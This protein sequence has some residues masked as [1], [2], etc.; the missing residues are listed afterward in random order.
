M[1]FVYLFSLILLVKY[2]KNVF[3]VQIVTVYQFYSNKANNLGRRNPTIRVFVEIYPIDHTVAKFTKSFHTSVVLKSYVIDTCKIIY[4]HFDR[5]AIIKA[6]IPR[7]L[8]N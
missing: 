1:N 7:Y 6:T 3:R 5:M 4:G 8:L 2:K